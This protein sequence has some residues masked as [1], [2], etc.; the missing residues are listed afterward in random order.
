MKSLEYFFSQY[1]PLTDAS[2]LIR[3]FGVNREMEKKEMLTRPGEDSSFLAF[4]HEGA[5]R[6]YFYNEK[7]HDT[8]VWF[9]F[10]GMMISDLLA[11]YQGTPANFYISAIEDSHI[12]LIYR[13]QLEEL[14]LTYPEYREFGRKYAENALVQV[15]QRMVTLQTKSAEER[16]A[17]LLAAPQFMQTIP[18]KYLATYLG[19]TDTSLSRIRKNLG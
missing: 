9:S 2:D 1:I 10:A 3:A 17:E 12:S 11:F 8:T 16:Y 18:L 14:Y 7:G 13:H 4:I 5:F 19:I 15:M 6:V